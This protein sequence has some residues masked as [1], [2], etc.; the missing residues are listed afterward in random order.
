MKTARAPVLSLGLIAPA[1]AAA[2]PPA[3]AAGEP[4]STP[5]NR[6]PGQEARCRP[7][8]EENLL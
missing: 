3:D 7:A 1:G 5:P 4:E 8:A 2:S 6:G